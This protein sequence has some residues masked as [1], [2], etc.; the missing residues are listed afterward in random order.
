MSIPS[1]HIEG[2]RGLKQLKIPQ[3]ASVNL[4]VGKNS[5]GKSTLL[6][7][8]ALYF[9]QGN[10]RLLL[11][12]LENR[13]EMP[14]RDPF[15]QFRNEAERQQA[16][17]GLQNL[18]YGRPKLNDGRLTLSIRANDALQIEILPS[19]GTSSLP[20][21]AILW[22]GA[23][24]KQESINTLLHHPQAFS[25][26]QLTPAVI[27]VPATSLLPHDIVNYWNEITLTPLEDEVIKA[28]NFVVPD[29]TRLSF[30]DTSTSKI[31]I[32]LH[33]NERVALGSLG[34]GLQK[35]LGLALA[36]TNAKDGYFII[37]EIGTGLHYTVQT[38]MWEFLMRTA[39]ELNVQVFAT[40]HSSD[41]VRAFQ[42]VSNQ[43]PDVEGQMIRLEKWRDEMTAVIIDEELMAFALD[44]DIE[45]R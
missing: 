9:T 21:V 17:E 36:L 27:Y 29:I 6:E 38:Q 24:T 14:Y 3:L 43:L 34:E 10:P 16:R 37:D 18:F 15:E 44:E 39:K 19:N 7:A 45:V 41:C 30:L 4:I 1:I 5:V 11:S 13:Q 23:I 26:N 2:Y 33:R 8:L 35:M 42:Y 22:N 20:E 25:P 12:F 40:T 32:V 28:L 31:P